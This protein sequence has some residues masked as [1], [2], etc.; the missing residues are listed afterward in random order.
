METTDWREEVISNSKKSYHFASVV[1]YY[2]C[3]ETESHNMLITCKN[4]DRNFQGNYCN[5]C[6][7]PAE[8]HKMNIHFLWH[9]IQHGLF[10]FDKGMLFSAKELFTRPGHSI[11]EYIEGKRVQHFKPISLVIVLATLY[12]LLYHTFHI[13]LTNSENTLKGF[14]EWTASH[15]SWVTLAT[16]PFYTLGTFI[17][18][19]KSGYNIIEFIILNTYKA[20]QRLIF[21]ITTF[22]LLYYFNGTP[23]IRII[24]IIIYCIDVLL[25]F[26]TNIQFFD[27]LSFKKV[28]L[29]SILS[30]LI[31]LISFS[32]TIAIITSLIYKISYF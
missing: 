2:I 16:I 20:S 18:F 25:I 14:N 10:H 8:T 31:F 4:C 5:N 11:R 26:W 21:H 32:I 30:H 22:P 23:T 6:G 17:C 9:D 1:F 12:G 19:R 7:Q 13:N 24:T 27:N 15:Y 3:D 29:R 28:L